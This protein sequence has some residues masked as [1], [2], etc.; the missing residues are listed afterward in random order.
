MKKTLKFTLLLIAVLFISLIT[1]TSL[2]LSKDSK[3]KTASSDI[4]S[5]IDKI[6]NSGLKN[7]EIYL[8]NIEVNSLLQMA[9]NDKSNMP[10]NIKG[11]YSELKENKIK[12]FM[13]F[14]FKSIDFVISS[15]GSIN[16][17]KDK[18]VYD[19]DYIKLG[20][21]KL[22]FNLISKMLKGK[23]NSHIIIN[24][25]QIIVNKDMVP[26][27]LTALTIKNDTLIMQ[28]DKNN[29][30]SS[31]SLKEIVSLPNKQKNNDIRVENSNLSTNESNT[32]KIV[33]TGNDSINN[34][35][36]EKVSALIQVENELN[37]A[38]RIT[39][40]SNSQNIILNMQSTINKMVNNPSYNYNGDAAK[41]KESYS[42]LSTEEK[43]D[44][45][46]AIFSSVKPSTISIIRNA[47]GL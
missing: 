47:F 30:M 33:Q 2:A 1:I 31:Q 40:S 3:Y 7:E 22:P 25:N 8:N 23:I 24:N 29:I 43:N 38:L 9:F 13:P 16:L 10:I 20:N 19:V 21:L 5:T 14:S 42:K 26:I 18:I 17:T 15:K 28:V 36:N 39:N 45:K 4:V 12:L 44:V 11:I 35:Y 41:V 32:N 46:R 6:K 37:S 27:S 34:N